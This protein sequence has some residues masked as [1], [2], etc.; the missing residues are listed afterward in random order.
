MNFCV[1]PVY[2]SFPRESPFDTSYGKSVPVD[3]FW[4]PLLYFKYPSLDN[5]RCNVLEFM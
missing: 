3:Y 2:A 5:K 4:L 1:N